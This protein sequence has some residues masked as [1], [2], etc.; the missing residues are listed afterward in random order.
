MSEA[1]NVMVALIK[2]GPNLVRLMLSLGW[3]Y[4][5]LWWRVRRARRAFEKQLMLR[6]MSKEDAK[7][8]S[9][10]FV[11][12]KNSL[13]GVLKVGAFSFRSFEPE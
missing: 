10:A 4:V 5:T 13:V 1:S 9:Y 8:L 11:E 6:G 7:R 3:M 2:S 12:L